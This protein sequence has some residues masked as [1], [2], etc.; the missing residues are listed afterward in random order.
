MWFLESMDR[1]NRAIQG[2]IGLDELM[3]DVLE[4]TLSIFD[5]DRAVLAH[6]C[7]PS[8]DT[9]SVIVE[10][11]RPEHARDADAL[12]DVP[13]TADVA[14]RCRVLCDADGPVQ[15]GPGS[16]R[17]LVPRADGFGVQSMIATAIYPHAAIPPLKTAAA[18]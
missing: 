9:W 8:A 5:C 7:D 14:E 6:P 17:A 10:R 12:R 4:A 16:G 11:A 13:M 1:V 15:F 3:E 2:A 18:P